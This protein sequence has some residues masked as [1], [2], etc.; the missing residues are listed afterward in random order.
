MI[1]AEYIL[2]SAV[3]F[4]FAGEAIEWAQRALDAGR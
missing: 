3:T 1:S 2:M 4:V